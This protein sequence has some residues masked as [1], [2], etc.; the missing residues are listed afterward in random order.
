MKI[1]IFCFLLPA[2]LG[3]SDSNSLF[4][5]LDLDG[6][7]ILQLNESMDFFT[8]MDTNDDG[9]V[10]LLEYMA[11]PTVGLT[12]SGVQ[13]AYNNYDKLD[14]NE[15]DVIDQSVIH[16]IYEMMDTNNDGEI[17]PEEYE[18]NSVGIWKGFVDELQALKE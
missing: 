8:Q 10:S 6:N 5:A 18:M 14:G 13:A 12:P 9:Q 2:F 17:S 11:S 1:L 15:D 7:G 16:F 4:K 3:A